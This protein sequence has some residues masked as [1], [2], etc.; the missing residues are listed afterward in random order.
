MGSRAGISPLDGEGEEERG[1]HVGMPPLV[2]RL[3]DRKIDRLNVAFD[4]TVLCSA[5]LPC[6]CD[7]LCCALPHSCTVLCCCALLCWAVLL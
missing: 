2:H 4:V 6:C 1:N 3:I 5:V 7:V